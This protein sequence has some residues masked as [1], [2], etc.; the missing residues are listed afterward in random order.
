MGGTGAAG[1][2]PTTSSV[3]ILVGTAGWSDGFLI[4]GRKWVTA[5]QKAAGGAPNVMVGDLTKDPTA[6]AATIQRFSRDSTATTVPTATLDAN[7]GGLRGHCLVFLT[8]GLEPHDPT[9]TKK[10]KE[11]T[12]GLLFFNAGKG[13][14]PN[15]VV[16]FNM[17]LD[18]MTAKLVATPTSGEDKEVVVKPELDGLSD[19]GDGK[20]FKKDTRAFAQFLNAMRRSIFSRVYLAACGPARRLEKFAEKLKLLTNLSVYWNDDTISFPV[21]GTGQPLVAEVGPIVNGVTSPVRQGLRYFK[22][23]DPANM[24]LLRS[25]TDGFLEGSMRRQP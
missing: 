6:A 14:N 9:L 5:I 19:D 21:P 20:K 7:L 17:H 11:D 24:V 12:Q 4:E 25:K 16:L 15:D 2:A 3:G 10:E 1:P 22:P 18:F 23:D 13:D 8:H